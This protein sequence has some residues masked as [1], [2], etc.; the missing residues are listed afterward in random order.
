MSLK[1]NFKSTSRTGGGSS[2]VPKA[3]GVSYGSSSGGG[4]SAPAKAKPTPA[5]A[6]PKVSGNPYAKKAAGNPYAKKA[7]EPAA[8][9]SG[10]GGGDGIPTDVEGLTEAYHAHVKEIKTAKTKLATKEIEIARLKKEI[11]SLKA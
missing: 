3:G 10:G 1:D 8:A 4:A 11:A 9:P 2:G 6:K 7:E 5:A